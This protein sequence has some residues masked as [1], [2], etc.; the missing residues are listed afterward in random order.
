M[1]GI[2]ALILGEFFLKESRELNI[3]RFVDLFAL[4]VSPHFIYTIN[5]DTLRLE[6]PIFKNH[7]RI[8]EKLKHHNFYKKCV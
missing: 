3:L 2:E 7:M 6:M 1:N 8:V 4:L 5:E